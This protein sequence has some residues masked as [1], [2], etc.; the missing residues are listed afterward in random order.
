MRVPYDPM[1]SG[2]K[3]RHQG[4]EKRECDKRVI[5]FTS[6]CEIPVRGVELIEGKDKSEGV[7]PTSILNSEKTTSTLRY[8]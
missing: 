1:K 6:Y 4:G 5:A 7:L 8:L 3:D 2:K